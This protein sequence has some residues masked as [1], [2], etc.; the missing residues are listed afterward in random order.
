MSVKT[1]YEAYQQLPEAEKAYFL[2]L[3]IQAEDVH[4][5]EENR[6]HEAMEELAAFLEQRIAHA[7]NNGVSDK[8]PE[9]I[10]REVL[11]RNKAL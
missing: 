5:I 10:A 7:E 1:L 4:A 8:T 6:Y 2:S 11:R 9:D 3:L